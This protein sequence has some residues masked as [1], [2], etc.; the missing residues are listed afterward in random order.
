M[1]EGV[2]ETVACPCGNG[3]AERRQTAI[4]EAVGSGQARTVQETHLYRHD[5][6]PIGG[7]IVTSGGRIIRR[8]GPLFKSGRARTAALKDERQAGA[9][10][11]EL[12]ADGGVEGE[13]PG[14]EGR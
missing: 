6:C 3:Y 14:G 9:V 1:S 8:A 10:D 2:P 7:H 12:A 11:G 5:G 13:G 4:R